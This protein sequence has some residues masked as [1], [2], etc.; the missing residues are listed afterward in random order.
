MKQIYNLP[1]EIRLLPQWVCWC[2]SKVPKNPKT[3]GNAQSNNADSW[4]SFEQAIE[5][6]EK[7][8]FDGVLVGN[9]GRLHFQKNQ[10]FLCADLF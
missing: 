7:F 1:E 2:G 10:A 5:A 9:I 8:G 3:G 6:C 4:A